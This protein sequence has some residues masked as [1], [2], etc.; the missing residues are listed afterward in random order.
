MKMFV[1]F[2]KSTNTVL[3]G[4]QGAPGAGSGWYELWGLPLEPYQQPLY[5]Y[6]EASN[7]VVQY[8]GAINT[9]ESNYAH[10]RFDAYPT[11]AEQF[12]MLWHDINNGTLNVQGTFY[13]TLQGVKNA[14]PKPESS[15][16][17]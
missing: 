1:K 13:E 16:G 7:T 8:G 14:H 12:D 9:P 10:N 6:N 3:Q 5:E 2:D 15:D 4:P 11:L 17:D